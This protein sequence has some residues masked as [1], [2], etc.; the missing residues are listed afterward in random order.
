[1]LRPMITADT[2]IEQLFT[3]GLI[4]VRTL[5]CLR[6]AQFVT[7]GQVLSTIQADRDLLRVK[8]L[9]LKSLSELTPLLDILRQG[10]EEEGRDPAPGAAQGW[11][12]IIAR[13]YSAA[14]N[15]TDAV[16]D[17]L[18]STY[19]IPYSLHKAIMSNDPKLMA[20]FK[21]SDKVV[22]RELTVQ[23]RQRFLLFIQTVLDADIGEGKMQ[24][25]VR[26]QYA[27]QQAL[28]TDHLTD[29]TPQEMLESLTPERLAYA[30]DRF[31][32]LCD[33]RLRHCPQFRG[34]FMPRLA[35]A[36]AYT[37]VGKT[38]K[39]QSVQAALAVKEASIGEIT[40]I[41]ALSDAEFWRERLLHH[42]PFLNEEQCLFAIE[43][44]QQ[45]GHE[46]R[47]FLLYHFMLSAESRGERSHCMYNRRFGLGCARQGL[48][49][50][51]EAFS[52]TRERVRQIT[53]GTNSRLPVYNT[54]Y[55]TADDWQQYANLWREP[56][57][58][59]HTP[60]L[61]DIM[62]RE[63]LEADHFNSLAHLLSRLPLCSHVY[64]EV[65][66]HPLLILRSVAEQVNVRQLSA[67]LQ[68]CA[69][70]RY[71][72]D[73]RVALS[74]LAACAPYRFQPVA[75]DLISYLATHIYHIPI[76][77]GHLVLRQN[78]VDVAAELVAI[79]ADAG[80]PMGL[81]ELF[82]A[83]KQRNPEHRYNNDTADKLVPFLLRDERVRPIGRTG[84]YALGEWNMNTDT[85]RGI[86][87]KQLQK[88]D[89][90]L[91]ISELHEA[92]KQ[93]YPN[94]SQNS[95]SANMRHETFVRIGK[96][97]YGLVA[98]SYEGWTPP[99]ATRRKQES[100]N[101]GGWLPFTDDVFDRSDS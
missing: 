62:Q 39:L 36:V 73:V 28:L 88:S 6:A 75:A 31:Q 63:H 27:T 82:E 13:A 10:A 29:Y 84:R 51:A 50:I 93:Y 20:A 12:G 69:E 5:N 45:W 60:S 100:A 33:E 37:Y 38:P 65:K 87:I 83:F 61:I 47:F 55:I 54:P 90:P 48:N 97:H 78:C 101:E 52:L 14:T 72:A 44:I 64:I 15:G 17:Y 79:L 98:K 46:P 95:L 77:Q 70:G 74:Y 92:V 80:K 1:M 2:T 26:D 35:D 21:G 7:L 49:D 66:E 96:N 76:E 58:G 19:P 81:N 56:F 32:A 89:T 8:G 16:A 94:V 18:H 30:E 41:A 24:D 40:R 42:H 59:A 57:I 68:Q 4:R 3:S 22:N 11:Q 34:R 85:I 67:D 71:T 25:I 53:T 9:G 23:L 99:P 91:H 86:L 43:Y